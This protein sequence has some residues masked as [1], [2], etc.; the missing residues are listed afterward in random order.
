MPLQ[1]RLP[2]G[3][4]RCDA[5][6]GVNGTTF[7]KYLARNPYAREEFPDD[8]DSRVSAMCRCHGPLCRGC[9]VNRIH[10][11]IS[12]HYYESTNRV[13]HVP[14][15]AAWGMCETCN[16]RKRE[17]DLRAT[18][19]SRGPKDKAVHAPYELRPGDSA[20]QANFHMFQLP[21]GR[22]LW[23]HAVSMLPTYGSLIAGLPDP[24][25]DAEL[26]LRSRN[27]LKTLWGDRPTHVIPPQYQYAIDG[28]RT[29]LQMPAMEF[30]VWLGSNQIE[31][32]EKPSSQLAVIWFGHYDPH[33]NL[34][35]FI[36]RELQ[37]LDWEQLAGGCA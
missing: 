36:E 14:Y 29:W 3:F 33:L 20:R 13:L 21:S 26:I 24:E 19:A 16:S 32:S 25:S 9:G 4:V 1:S 37:S 30:H 12:G 18:Q 27:R 10:R 7:E 22:F 31:S 28:G 35:R 5:C 8:P 2:P 34:Y 17:N 15:F 11:P 6:G 23:L